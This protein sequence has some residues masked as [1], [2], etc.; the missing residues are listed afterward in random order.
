[1][2][3]NNF[4]KK[5]DFSDRMFN[6]SRGRSR[7]WHGYWDE[8]HDE[9]HQRFNRDFFQFGYSPSSEEIASWREFFHQFFGVWPEDHWI[10]GGRRFGPLQQGMDSFNPFVATLLSK[11]GGLLP[12]YVLH[13]VSQQPRY[14]NEIMDIL[15][16]R[17]NGQWV[18][19]PGAVYPLLN[20]L[21]REGFISGEWADPAKRTV[22]TYSITDNGKEELYRIKGVVGPKIEETISVLEG[23]M[24]DLQDQPSE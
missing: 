23:L 1:M 4:D 6:K 10:F 8:W 17:T 20:Q 5:R 15:A 22:R 11:G 2:P 18:S 13:L 7:W 3:R 19:N 14:G 12:L 21:E 16:K 24:Q 9:R